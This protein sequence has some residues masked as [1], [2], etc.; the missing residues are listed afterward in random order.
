MQWSRRG[1]GSEGMEGVKD[2]TWARGLGGGCRSW[3]KGTVRNI[4]G[5]L[6]FVQSM[7]NNPQNI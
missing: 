1:C 5:K 3:G 2:D 4:G 6:W 7:E